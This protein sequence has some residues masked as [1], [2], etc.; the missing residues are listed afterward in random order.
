[1]Q[2]K[3]QKKIIVAAIAAVLA[4]PTVAVATSADDLVNIMIKKG[5]LTREEGDQLMKLSAMDKEAEA[6]KQKVEAQKQSNE[7]ITSFKDGI[8]WESADKEFK[9]S[10]NGRVQADYRQFIAPNTGKPNTFDIRRAYLGV[11][12]RF[13]KNVEF[14]TLADF[15]KPSAASPSPM[16]E[17]FLNLNYWEQAQLKIG[18]FKM[19]MGMEELGSS[20][21]INFQERSMA[22]SLVPSFDRG[23]QL[24][25]VPRKGVYYALA[26]SNGNMTNTGL[27]NTTE[28]AG[29]SAAN[30]GKDVTGRLTFNIADL[31]GN[32]Q[33][34]VV[35]VGGAFSRGDQDGNATQL[36]MATE[37]RGGTFF[38]T[39]AGGYTAGNRV[40]VGRNAFELALAKGPVKFSSEYVKASFDNAT[41][42]GIAAGNRDLKSWYAA[43]NWNITGESYAPTYDSAS[44]KFGKRLKPNQNFTGSGS[45]WGAWEVG[46]RYS[47]FD[48]TNF[49][50]ADILAA[51]A[52]NVMANNANATTLG[53][54]WIV[55]PHTRFLLNYVKTDF[56]N[57]AGTALVNGSASEKAIT[58]RGQ[59]D[60]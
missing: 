45:G 30:D 17:Y 27:Q 25:G 7:V 3:M 18:Q 58:F 59:V 15:A 40:K 51:T 28:P 39:K 19:P 6:Q 21:F 42:A 60:F 38:S 31:M 49:A 50:V 10:I 4:F 56:K 22:M 44:A 2:K 35:H 33:D 9:M 16:I 52:T 54:K 12:G 57:A 41:A 20:R 48:A 26:V 32:M 1:M 29:G 53:L 43:A 46:A 5:M 34:A 36:T 47:K 11:K 55:N 13:Y 24:H 8:S 14:E 37:A 23:I